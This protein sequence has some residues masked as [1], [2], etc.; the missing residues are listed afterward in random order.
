MVDKEGFTALA[1]CK[2]EALIGSVARGDVVEGVDNME[3]GRRAEVVIE[4]RALEGIAVW[5]GAVDAEWGV[6]DAFI[7]VGW[8][9]CNSFSSIIAS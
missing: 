1:P 5:D 7:F 3:G 9:P 2:T 4:E 8:Q 6:K